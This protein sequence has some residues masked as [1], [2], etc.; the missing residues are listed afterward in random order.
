MADNSNGNPINGGNPPPDRNSSG[1]PSVDNI[2]RNLASISGN[3]EASTK[4]FRVFRIILLSLIG[5]LRVSFREIPPCDK[6]V[7]KICSFIISSYLHAEY[8][9]PLIINSGSKK[10]PVCP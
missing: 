4:E 6:N 8:G 5:R 10:L 7:I 3:M 9:F 2:L 1:S